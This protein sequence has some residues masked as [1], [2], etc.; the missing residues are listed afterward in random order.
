MAIMTSKITGFTRS[1]RGARSA[2]EYAA[3]E[4]GK[5]SIVYYYDT[6]DRTGPTLKKYEQFDKQNAKNIHQKHLMNRRKKRRRQKNMT[7]KVTLEMMIPLPAADEA[8]MVEVQHAVMDLIIDRTQNSFLAY[9][10]LDKGNPHLHVCYLLEKEEFRQREDYKVFRDQVSDIQQ[11]YKEHYNWGLQ[12]AEHRHSLKIEVL[13]A[14]D[15]RLEAKNANEPLWTLEL[16]LLLEKIEKNAIRKGLYSA[17]DVE[18]Y[19]TQQLK[20]AGWE[21][22]YKKSR[23]GKTFRSD[24][25]YNK[26]LGRNIGIRRVS[27]Y[28]TFASMQQHIAT[29]AFQFVAQDHGRDVEM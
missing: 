9:V 4:R 25:L 16:M 18:K 11:K 17:A 6:H 1:N 23:A 19:T 27:K 29:Q 10:H 24:I 8:A 22:I 3:Q 7:K 21:R 13:R 12:P 15:R 26:N 28:Q 2:I 5:N 14:I 20:E